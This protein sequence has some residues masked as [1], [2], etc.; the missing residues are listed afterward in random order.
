[1]SETIYLY[2][3]VPADAP[4]PSA[5]LAG[6]AGAEV[7]L[8]ELDGVAAAVSRVPGDAYA[9]AAIEPR[10]G[11]LGWVSEQGVQHER[12]VAWFVDH[13]QIL[14]VR[15]LTLYSSLDTLRDDAA[16]R[17]PAIRERMRRFQGRREWDVKVSYRPAVLERRIGEVSEAVAALDRELTEASPGRRYLLQRKRAD[18]ATAE[19]GRSARELADR[20]Y[21]SL[22]PRV[23][24]AARVPLPREAAELPVV[25]NAALLVRADAEPELHAHV[26][27]EAGRLAELG[28]EVAFSGPWA[29]YRFMG[30]SDAGG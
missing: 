3:F 10:L 14:P 20:F 15:L 22:G 4:L 17:T 5:G 23:E 8:V 1:M 16:E 11:D 25:L 7:E 27:A 30:E 13:A 26:A 19:L 12:V 6:I 18:L 2:G 9:P 21:A 29:P 24:H 28:L